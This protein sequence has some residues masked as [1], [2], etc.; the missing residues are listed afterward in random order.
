M[1]GPADKELDFSAYKNFLL[2]ER[3]TLQLRS[4]FFNLFNHTNFGLPNGTVTSSNFGVINSANAPREIQFA[5]K[6]SF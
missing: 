3:F 5:L 4:E 1:T 6:L 2:T